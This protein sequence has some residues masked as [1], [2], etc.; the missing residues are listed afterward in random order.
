MANERLPV[1]L[2][3]VMN[4]ADV[5]VIQRGRGLC[6]A[7]ETGECLLVAGNLLGQELQCDEAV[8]PRVLGFIDH[9]HTAATE[10]FQ[11]AVVGDGLPDE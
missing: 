1:L 5:W 11:D 9:T 2:S 8:K 7:L 10:L 3:D 4:C 6:F